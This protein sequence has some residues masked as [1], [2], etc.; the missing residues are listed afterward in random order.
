MPYS[1][2]SFGLYFREKDLD[3]AI[4][5]LKKCI[6]LEPDYAPA[7]YLLGRCYSKKNDV[8]QVMKYYELYL[9]VVPPKGARYQHVKDYISKMKG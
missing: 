7:L 2:L 9:N 1:S 8:N 3:Q 5:S 6:A 4:A